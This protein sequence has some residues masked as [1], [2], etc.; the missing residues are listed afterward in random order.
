[1]CVFSGNLTW[2]VNT[3]SI[4]PLVTEKD[5]PQGVQV[6]FKV[7]LIWLYT[8]RLSHTGTPIDECL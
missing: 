5:L 7:V 8:V 2:I 6:V 4:F 3:S 1:M